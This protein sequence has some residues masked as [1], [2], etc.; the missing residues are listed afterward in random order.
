MALSLS[1]VKVKAPVIRLLKMMGI[2]LE[3]KTSLDVTS[4]ITDVIR[5]YGRKLFRFIRGKVSSQEEAEDILQEVWYQLIHQDDLNGI[6]SMSGW[7]HRVARNKVTDL[8]RKS[9]PDSLDDLVFRDED[10]DLV[11]REILLSENPEDHEFR[12]IFWE[13]IMQA[14]DELP[15]NQRSVFVRNEFDG[16]TLQEIADQDGEK[17]KTIISRKTYAVRHLRERLQNLYLSLND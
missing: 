9:H 12:E 7:L 5:T 1:A 8:Y 2:S 16:F 14:L 17:I 4:D 10:G 15:E 13:E 6:E 3:R 11:M